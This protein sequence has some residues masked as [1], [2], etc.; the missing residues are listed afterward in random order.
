MTKA[1]VAELENVSVTT[2]EK[3]MREGLAVPG[4]RMGVVAMR[5]KLKYSKIK[6]RVTI[7]KA[8][9]REFSEFRGVRKW[10]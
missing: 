7:K 3:W 8:D 5:V 6:N 4:A 1:E 9:Y 10:D 2:V